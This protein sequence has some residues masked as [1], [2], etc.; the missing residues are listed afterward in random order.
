MAGRVKATWLA[1]VRKVGRTIVH[2]YEG[3]TCTGFTQYVHVSLSL[4]R[5][6][7][8]L[9]SLTLTVEDARKWANAVNYFAD[10]AES[11]NK[12]V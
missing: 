7:D 11:E 1:V 12:S 5:E 3:N 8:R 6:P 4:E 9:V 2:H 10:L